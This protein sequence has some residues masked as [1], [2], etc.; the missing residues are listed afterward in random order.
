VAAAGP[1]VGVRCVSLDGRCPPGR[2]A[3]PGQTS[4]RGWARSGHG[5]W[6]AEASWGLP[7]AAASTLVRVEFAA[8]RA[9]PADECGVLG[10][11]DWPGREALV[12]GAVLVPGPLK[13]ATT[14][15]PTTCQPPGRLVKPMDSQA[16]CGIAAGLAGEV[17]ASASPAAVPAIPARQAP[18]WTVWMWT[19]SGWSWLRGAI[20]APTSRPSSRAQRAGVGEQAGRRTSS[21]SG[22]CSLSNTNRWW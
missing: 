18:T 16:A 19:S 14:C 21:Q 1:V 8:V 6:H 11:G 9:V 20:T 2:R 3:R 13:P 7:D 4:W 17:E 22:R 12:D 10:V 15:T 5:R